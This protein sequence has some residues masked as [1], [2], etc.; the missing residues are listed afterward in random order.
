MTPRLRA[1][2]ATATLL[3]VPLAQAQQ[4]TEPAPPA[5]MEEGARPGAQGA[6]ATRMDSLEVTEKRDAT[7]E[8]R[9]STAS[10]IVIGRDEIEQYGDTNMGDVLRRLPGVTQSGRPGRRGGI[11][12]RG[13]AGG[14]TQ[15]LINGERI[16]SGFSIEDI[17]PEQV[18]RIEILRAPTAETGTRAIAGTINIILREALRERRNTV[19]AGVQEENGQL[20]PTRPTRA[21]TSSPAAAATTSPFP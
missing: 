16:P 8:R 13:M 2:A 17:E 4:G 19:K 1:L 10:K 3:F 20:P 9:D 21:T 6:T 7:S 5:A 12:M 14:Y 11:R 15:I 18:E